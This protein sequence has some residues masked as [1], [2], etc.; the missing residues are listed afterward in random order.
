[1]R[2][3]IR[4]DADPRRRASITIKAGT[5]NSTLPAP[6]GVSRNTLAQACRAASA[7]LAII[8]RRG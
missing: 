6:G 2:F 8:T 5:L 3:D 1:M 4:R 7:K